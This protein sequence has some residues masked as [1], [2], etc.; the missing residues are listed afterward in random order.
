MN[1]SKHNY[2]KTIFLL[3]FPIILENIF[4][5]LLG[6]TDTYFAGKLEDNAI[7][8]I[9]VTS[10]IMNIFLAF[11]TAISVGVS[12]VISRMIGQGETKKAS[13]AIS[14][15][16]ILGLFLGLILGLLSFLFYQ[17][18]LRLSGADQS[19]LEYAIPYYFVVVIPSIFLCLSL[20]FSSCLRAMKDTKTPM[21]L[22]GISN[23]VNILL[24]LLFIKAGLGI[25]G[26]G[27]ATT[28]SRILVALLLFMKLKQ[29]QVGTKISWKE[30]K[31]QKEIMQSMIKVSIPAGIEKL[32]MRTGQ[33]VY[34]GM[35]ISLGTAS[36]VAHNIGG[37]IE[38]YAYIPAFGF[39]MATATLVGIS[40]GEHNSE[41]AK[42]ITFLSN[43]IT[44]FIMISIGVVFFVFA[45]QLASIFTDTLEVQEKVTS[46]LRLI[47]FFQPFAALTQI[48][49][50]ALQGAGDTKFPMYATLLGIWVIR[51]GI[52]YLLAV[53]CSLGLFG[54]WCGYAL[55]LTIRGILLLLRFLRGKWQ[56]IVL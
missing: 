25:L 21:F 39:G 24:N 36:Y 1:T 22:T 13:Y 19:V 20:V 6:T 29:H 35:I 15:A 49:S 34:N 2:A 31:I 10:L 26:L 33:L 48:M 55:D 9:G 41:K 32:I 46:V 52:G 27:L 5:T 42:K 37:S 16:L 38:G 11:Y 23:I 47:A 8:A 50:S 17:P 4:Q 28:I 51:V 43:K 30:L 12:A 56:D 53:Q 14:Q 45:P 44:T 54:V 40:L 18:I 7:A 3:A